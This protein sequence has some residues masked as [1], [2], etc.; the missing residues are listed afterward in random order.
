MTENQ[1]GIQQDV[2]THNLDTPGE[3]ATV[4]PA[5]FA[6]LGA[7]RGRG[8]AAD[9]RMLSDVPLDVTVELGR[10]VMKLKEL[11]TLAEGSVIE[12]NRTLGAPVDIIVNGKLVAR[13]DVVVVGDDFGVRVTEVLSPGESA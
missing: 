3:S 7:G 8:G 10:A 12:L 2:V 4:A 1:Q 5:S 13:G 6:D 11:L 9:L